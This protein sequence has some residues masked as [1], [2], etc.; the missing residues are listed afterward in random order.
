VKISQFE[1]LDVGQTVAEV[2]EHWAALVNAQDAGLTVYSPSSGPQWIGFV[3]PDPGAGSP[4]D[5]ATNH[6]SAL[7]SWTITPHIVAEGDIYLIAGDYHVARDVVYAL[8]DK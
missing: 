2:P 6:F 5:N 3:F 1:N 8:H 7:W 4:T